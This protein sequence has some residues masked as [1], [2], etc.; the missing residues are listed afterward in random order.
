LI[1][2]G[3]PTDLLDEFDLPRRLPSPNFIAAYSDYPFDG[4]EGFFFAMP[5]RQSPSLGRFKMVQC[6]RLGES[7]GTFAGFPEFAAEPVI[8]E[9]ICWE[10]WGTHRGEQEGE[11]PAFRAGKGQG[12]P[13]L[14][15][16]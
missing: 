5:K 13:R 2:S 8:S 6:T 15:A 3:E 4:Q 7:I 10:Q 14:R 11:N 16:R 1:N 12:I 9:R